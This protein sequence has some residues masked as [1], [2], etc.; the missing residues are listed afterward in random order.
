MLKYFLRKI[1]W[2]KIITSFF[3]VLIAGLFFTGC[4]EL[5]II[6]QPPKGP[7]LT[8]ATVLPTV[9]Q[10]PGYLDIFWNSSEIAEA[11][12][13]PASPLGLSHFYQSLSRMRW[14]QLLKPPAHGFASPS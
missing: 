14:E 6:G 5:K 7:Q 10:I 2:Q 1:P 9:N 12:T 13:L 4:T 8:T 11:R 3:T